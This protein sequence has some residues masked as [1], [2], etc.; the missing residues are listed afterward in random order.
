MSTKL[1]SLRTTAL[2]ALG[3][4]FALACGAFAA[5]AYAQPAER[6]CATPDDCLV[7]EVA[8]MINALPE[9]NEIAE[10]N[11]TAVIEQIH[12]IDRIK[13]G[14]SDEQYDELLQWVE[15]GENGS[16]QGLD[17]PKR[18][19]DAVAAI[20]NFGGNSL[21]VDKKFVAV[22]GAKVDVSDAQVQLR[23]T[24]VDGDYSQV[25]TLTSMDYQPNSLS[26]DASFY[27]ENETGDGWTYGYILPAGTYL[28]EEISDSG[29]TVD[30][31]EFVTASTTYS[32][33]GAA[34]AKG[35]SATVEV[36]GG[37]ASTV[38]FENS[39]APQGVSVSVQFEDQFG[40]PLSD[41]I[42][43]SVSVRFAP[44]EEG[45]EASSE[46]HYISSSGGEVPA[47]AYTLSASF[48]SEGVRKCCFNS[49][50]EGVVFDT[51]S[52]LTFAESQFWAYENFIQAQEEI[53]AEPMADG[54]WKITLTAW[55]FSSDSGPSVT[56]K[57]VDRDGNPIA[58][59]GDLGLHTAYASTSPIQ[60]WTEESEVTLS[61]LAN[62]TYNMTPMTVHGE[63]YEQ[64]T[65]FVEFM[66]KDGKLVV[67]DDYEADLY[68]P[69]GN[70]PEVIDTKDD[71]NGNY[72]ITVRVASIEYA[73]F[74]EVINFY[75][76]LPCKVTKVEGSKE[77]VVYD[78][79]AVDEDGNGIYYEYSYFLTP[80]KYRVYAPAEDGLRGYV[81]FP[82]ADAYEE[83]TITEEY[84]FSST[85]S[86]LKYDEGTS[87]V[88]YIL[89]PAKTVAVTAKISTADGSCFP[90][91]MT[92]DVVDPE[93][94][95]SALYTVE[96]P[97][98]VSEYE[99]TVRLTAWTY[100]E[101]EDGD[102]VITPARYGVTGW[103]PYDGDVVFTEAGEGPNYFEATVSGV[104]AD[105]ETGELVKPTLYSIEVQ[106]ADNGSVTA[107]REEA[108]AG[109]II[110]LTAVP[111]SGYVL[112]GLF[113]STD[114]SQRAA[115]A[116]NKYG[117]FTMPAGDVTVSATF[118]Q[119]ESV[120]GYVVDAETGVP[121]KD[122]QM[123]LMVGEGGASTQL[124]TG[125][126]GSFEV[127]PS[128]AGSLGSLA[129]TTADGYV[130][131]DEPFG[132]VWAVDGSID[133][134]SID[135]TV[136]I[137]E[138]GEVVIKLQREVARIPLDPDDEEAGYATD[139]DGDG[140]YEDRGGNQYIPDQDGDGYPE[141]DADKD[142][143]FEGTVD[144]EGGADEDGDPVGDGKPDNLY[145]PNDEGDFDV[146]SNGD[147]VFGPDE[148]DN[149]IED[150][151]EG[152]NNEEGGDNGD[153]PFVPGGD[154]DTP[155]PDDPDGGNENEN[156][157]GSGDGNGGNGGNGD[158]S[159]S[160]SDDGTSADKSDADKG[161]ASDVKKPVLAATGDF[162]L[163]AVVTGLA[164]VSF[165]GL[166][167]ALRARRIVG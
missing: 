135:T 30:G 26:A 57:F 70:S 114:A 164:L 7:C 40:N 6:H 10:S 52:G 38:V 65:G 162:A 88:R 153:D 21:A 69:Y 117:E 113:V 127:T 85:S 121:L 58:I 89:E 166:V 64:N 105:W 123:S 35:A 101:D 119:G 95:W 157:G 42:A 132:F 144:E 126:D 80:G 75:N 45:E 128:T 112:D 55:V 17:V 73:F 61:K 20:Q 158:N 110:T 165:V 79:E 72:T 82:A 32:V 59:D 159:G 22:D 137:N 96:V 120:K 138:N 53:K 148:N 84:T 47:G 28:V 106:A 103:H 50:D 149:G 108:A 2:A 146:D 160:D 154:P 78:T 71:G 23:I 68:A 86:A 133:S 31:A 143:I 33:N 19:V 14:L 150:A 54:G 46:Y 77:T 16:G 151:A 91:G 125:A 36:S 81:K 99:Y 136:D 39:H 29:A 124:T 129:V 67:E 34:S 12:A 74:T 3:L 60:G 4:A 139:S 24:S 107:S 83:F 122:V 41:D 116:V 167:L 76:G 5:N 156:G 104:G 98:T 90:E 155:D 9:A 15:T 163:P 62:G 8:G 141:P 1:L 27:S 48:D 147:D 43:R 111:D 49:W 97:T 152:D 142:G 140:I 145:K 63:G 44:Y 100:G 94:E 93:E 109:E 13:G 37:E 161:D 51:S 92:I 56:L 115:V 131:P 66:V 25:V 11:A 102:K 87:E 18:Y 130:V 134:S 118:K